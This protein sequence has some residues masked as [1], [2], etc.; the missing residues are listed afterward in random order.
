[1]CENLFKNCSSF[2]LKML[3]LTDTPCVIGRIRKLWAPSTRVIC[4]HAIN[5]LLCYWFRLFGEFGIF[6][7]GSGATLSFTHTHSLSHGHRALCVCVREVQM[8]VDATGKEWTMYKHTHTH[9]QNIHTHSVNVSESERV[10]G[11]ER[12]EM[13]GSTIRK[14]TRHQKK[15]LSKI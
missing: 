10:I 7:L 14:T 12:N 5:L 6:L 8:D 13:R 2:H 15:I 1:M 4:F 3:E 11:L 9:K